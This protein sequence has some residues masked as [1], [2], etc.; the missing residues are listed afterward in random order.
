MKHLIIFC[1]ATILGMSLS[2]AQSTISGTVKTKTNGKPIMNAMITVKDSKEASVATDINGKFTIKVPS[3]TVT[4][5]VVATGYQMKSVSIEKSD[6]VD[7]VLT[8]EV[9]KNAKTVLKAKPK[10]IAALKSNSTQL[11]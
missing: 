10:K 1:I 3:N 9:D 5:N 2:S 8:P 11:K 4:L 7:I 6:V